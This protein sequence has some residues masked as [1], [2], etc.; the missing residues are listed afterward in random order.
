ML[1]VLTPWRMRAINE[2]APVTR[3]EQPRFIGEP[4]LYTAAICAW[5]PTRKAL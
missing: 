4:S 2:P 5:L 1:T 3:L